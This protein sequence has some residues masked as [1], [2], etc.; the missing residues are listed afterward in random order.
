MK[1]RYRLIK[2]RQRLTFDVLL[3][4]MSFCGSTDEEYLTFKATN[5]VE[6]ISRSR[7]DIETDRLWLV[8]CKPNF[9][10][11]TKEVKDMGNE[12]FEV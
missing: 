2:T 11:K 6:I 12:M 9:K 5:G 7:M 10:E 3:Q 8:G 1:L 4:D